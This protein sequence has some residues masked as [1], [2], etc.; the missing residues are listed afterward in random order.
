MQSVFDKETKNNKWRKDISSINGVGK[1][2][3]PCVK[4]WNWT[5]FTALTKINLK[6]IKGLNVRS[7]T[8]QFPEDNVG[9]KFPDMD[10]GLGNDFFWD[11]T[12]KAQATK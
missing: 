7:N 4:E 8:T 3:Q 11:R 10:I 6:W 12:P 2:G 9:I 5:H 1:A